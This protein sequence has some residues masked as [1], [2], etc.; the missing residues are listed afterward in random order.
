MWDA[1]GAAGRFFYLLRAGGAAALLRIRSLRPLTLIRS[2]PIGMFALK[3]LMVRAGARRRG[4][5]NLGQ[6]GVSIWR[7]SI[8]PKCLGK[9]PAVG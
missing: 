4:S 1:K 6:G 7:L 8:L 5:S 2:S 9:F 3:T